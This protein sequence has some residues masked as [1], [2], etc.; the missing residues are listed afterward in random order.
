MQ[1]RSS[2]QA[3]IKITTKDA[4]RNDDGK[5]KNESNGCKAAC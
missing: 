1:R 2:I 4:L 3:Y 5:K